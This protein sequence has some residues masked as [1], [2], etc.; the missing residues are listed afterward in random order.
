MRE[1]RGIERRSDVLVDQNRK[2]LVEYTEV[3]LPCSVIYS[4]MTKYTTKNVQ[5]HWHPGVE[6][7]VVKSGAVR[8]NLEAGEYI[9]KKGEGGFINQN[10][11]HAT[12][13]AGGSGCEMLTF[14][15]SP[16]LFTSGEEN[17]LYKRIESSLDGLKQFP[18][19]SLDQH[20]PWKQEILRCM[21]EAYEVYREENIVGEIILM[22]KM[23]HI[24]RLIVQHG[25]LQIGEM[26]NVIK[27]QAQIRL[28][29]MLEYIHEHYA[30][31]VTLEDIAKA[32]GISGRECTRNFQNG[33]RMSPVAY[34]IKYRIEKAQEMLCMNDQSVT[35]V[36][37][38]TGFN[39]SSYFARM[40]KRYTGETPKKYQQKQS[41]E[42]SRC[43]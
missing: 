26:D 22:E 23:M 25:P 35:E 1:G 39:D 19:I 40:F 15:F 36:G 34:L 16:G 12:E 14:I 4:D 3:Y 42:Y 27:V 41:M 21:D 37:L 18:I 28:K 5:W 31:P 32:A 13:I 10:V 7:F 30:E 6:F 29:K 2:E 9:F 33:I 8:F 20:E 11:L 43:L 38:R 24:W 17:E